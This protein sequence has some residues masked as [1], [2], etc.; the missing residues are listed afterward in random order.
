MLKLRKIFAA[1]T[2]TAMLLVLTACGSDKPDYEQLK[3]DII[4]VWCD[5]DGPEYVPM[6][7]ESLSY[8]RM[9]E[10]TENDRLIYHMPDSFYGS[11]YTESAYSITDDIMTVD[12]KSRCKISIENDILTMTYND[13][14]SQYRR[15]TP[16]EAY[17]Y[18]A[19]C[20]GEAAYA[21]L[22]EYLTPDDNE[23]VSETSAA[24]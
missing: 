7:D 20:I 21:E 2:A 22:D 18:G 15:M 10:F 13:G 24:Q 11:Y 6:E 23:A 1:V 3:T 12:E 8:Y 9:Y 14:Y 19:I 16:V 5:V 4:G 17:E